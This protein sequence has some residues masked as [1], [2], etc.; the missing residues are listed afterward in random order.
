MDV[1]IRAPDYMAVI[2]DH[3][4]PPLCEEVFAITRDRE[5]QRKWT[6]FALVWFWIG[7]LQ[8]KHS[9]QTRAV[10]EGQKG[11]PLFPDVDA[12]PESFFLKIQNVRP[13]FFRNVFSAFTNAIRPEFPGNFQRNLGISEKDF[14]DIYAADGS[15]LAKVGRLLKVAR[16][17]TKAIIPGSM[18]GVYDL[19]RGCLHDLWFDPDGCV[20]EISMFKRVL[21]NI[22][23]G[24]LLATDRYYP[25]P[26]IWTE[27]ADL[28]LWMVSRYN[29]TVGK[30]KVKELARI[31]NSRICVDDWLVEMGGSQYGTEPV[32]LR[33]VHVWNSEFDMILITNVLDPKKLSP[34]QLISLY[35]QRWSVERMYLAMKEI[36]ELNHLFNANPA[37]VGQQTYATAILYNALRLAQAKIAHKAGISPETLSPDKLFPALMDRMIKALYIQMG[38]V[39][40]FEELTRRNPK[41]RKTEM[42]QIALDH[43]LLNLW[44]AEYLVE[45]RSDRRR[46]RR[47]C[48]GRKSWTSFNKIPGGKKYLRN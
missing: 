34:L 23:R 47:F 35:R 46:Q 16:N 31:R 5:R 39:L 10:L 41:M 32:L 12:S 37:A 13:A 15:R 40:M 6:L 3:L 48:Q 25:K 24:A 44:L 28:G 22:T 11:H 36:L 21:P 7:L 42:P 19:R 18:E 26:V 29:K 9:S 14:P 8:S 27:L 2:W 17:T 38:A 30:K 4:T 20:S 33:W 1:E 45:K 43:P